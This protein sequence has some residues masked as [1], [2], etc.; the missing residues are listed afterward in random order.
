[1][2]TQYPTPMTGELPVGNEVKL[3]TVKSIDSCFGIIFADIITP[4]IEELRLPIFPRRVDNSTLDLPHNTKWT[5]WY[6]TLDLQNAM[7]NKYKVFPKVGFHF[8]KGTPL[9]K[10]VYLIFPRKPDPVETAYSVNATIYKLI[11]ITL[12]GRLG[13]TYV[14]YKAKIVNNKD[15]GDQ[16]LFNHW[17][18]IPGYSITDYSLI[19]TGPYIDAKLIEI[20]KDTN[21]IPEIKIDKRKRGSL[22]SLPLAVHIT[23]TAR[24]GIYKFKF[25]PNNPLIYTDTDY[26]ILP[27]ILDSNYIGKELGDMKL[28]NKIS[29][30]IFIAKKLYAYKNTNNDVKIASAGINN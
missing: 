26:V 12:Y 2:N 20:I 19:K 27:K 29:K 15:I 13:F 3:M 10:Y 1:M 16:I 5:G 24:Y 22:S 28:E 18:L 8:E 21:D 7:Q 25:I 23:A 14:L 9:S 30:G 4:T 6:S 11:L 17:K